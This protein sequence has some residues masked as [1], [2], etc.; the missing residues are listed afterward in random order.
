MLE[1]YNYLMLFFNLVVKHYIITSIIVFVLIYFLFLSENKNFYS[2]IIKNKWYTII[3]GLF[4]NWKTQILTIFWKK[5]KELWFFVISNF[6]NWYS[7]LN[8]SS[9]K[10]LQNLLSDLLILWEYQNFNDEEFKKIYND[11]EVY[12]DKYNERNYIKK[13]KYIPNNGYHSKFLFLG[14][15]FHIYFDSR[16]SLW[17][18]KEIKL[19]I[20]KWEEIEEEKK[21]DIFEKEAKKLSITMHQIR[22]FN[23]SFILASQK[24]GHIDNRIRELATY[25]IETNNKKILRKYDLYRWYKEIRNEKEKNFDKINKV[26]IFKFNP[27]EINFLIKKF[28]IFL[29]K[30]I[31]S[32]NY[33]IIIWILILILFIFTKNVYLLFFLI[34]YIVISTTIKWKISEINIKYRMALLDYN[35]KYNVNPYYNIYKKWD[36]FRKL[37]DYYKKNN[38]YANVFFE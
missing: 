38:K 37:N 5:A 17:N 31:Y 10:D 16:E 18:F 36:I 13:F 15:E 25:E 29:N 33:K 32:K 11:K 23:T 2:R 9:K 35:T 4:N 1:L 34:L 30:I 21:E 28:E 19:K 20:K 24:I 6:Y 3:W 14:D 8:F 7:F 26:P 22:H 27:Y 12:K